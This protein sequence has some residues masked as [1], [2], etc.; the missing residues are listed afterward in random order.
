MMWTVRNLC[1]LFVAAWIG[2]AAQAVQSHPHV[3]VDYSIGAHFDQNGLVGFRQ[4]WIL[5]EMFSS[6]IVSMFDADENGVFSD[7]EME[8]VRK[9]VFDYLREYEYFTRIKIDGQDFEVRQ[10]TQFR[11]YIEGHHVVYEFFVPCVVAAASS[12]R[13]VQVLVED[14]EYFVEMTFKPNGLT[15]EGKEHV[16]VSSTFGS[17]D[18]FSFFGG[19]WRPKHLT[20]RFEKST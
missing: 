19:A 3:W 10:V 5:D 16:S 11:A 6:S 12:P 18:A 15:I 2:L 20:L 9:G 13:T 4:R 17:S 8:E 7:D 14:L 1:S